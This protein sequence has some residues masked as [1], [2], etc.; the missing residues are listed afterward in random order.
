M[1]VTLELNPEFE[2]G[3]LAQARER[4]VSLD[5]YLQEIIARQ[6]RAASGSRAA[7]KGPELPIR[8]LGAV[9]SLHRR[10][11]YDDT[12]SVLPR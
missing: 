2:Q 3:L 10:D 6:V 1:T 9:G 8:H 11:I 5:A 12:L 4:G 7:G